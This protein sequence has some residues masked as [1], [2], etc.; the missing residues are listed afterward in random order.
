M[1][2]DVQTIVFDIQDVGAR[3]YEHINILGF[4][5]EAAAEQG[6]EVVVLDRPNSI[7]GLRTDGFV[8][9]DSTRFRFGSYAPVPVQHG[10][11]MGELARLYHGERLLRGGRVPVLHVVPMVGVEA[12]DAVRR[13]RPR[14][15]SRR[16]T[17]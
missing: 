10:L 12:V 9:D 17:C 8:T 13:D 5:M 14:G 4:V 3:F 16:R 15:G 6:I 1:L 11:T 2:R 7:T